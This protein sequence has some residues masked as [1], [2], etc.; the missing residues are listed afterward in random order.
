MLIVNLFNRIVKGFLLYDIA[1]FDKFF[2][3]K[4]KEFCGEFLCGFSININC[5]AH[6]HISLF[7]VSCKILSN[8]SSYGML[9]PCKFRNWSGDEKTIMSFSDSTPS[10]IVVTS[11]PNTSIIHVGNSNREIAR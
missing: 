4:V 3:G 6:L 8:T 5:T 10:F 11:N 1:L 2:A 9:K 7:G